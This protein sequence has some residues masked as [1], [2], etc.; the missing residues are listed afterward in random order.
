VDRLYDQR[1]EKSRRDFV[2]G[3][4]FLN[5][6]RNDEALKR[7]NKFIGKYPDLSESE[8]ARK[9]VSELNKN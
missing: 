6:G 1:L 3:V 4:A 8:Q 2:L 9:L 5:L 7:L